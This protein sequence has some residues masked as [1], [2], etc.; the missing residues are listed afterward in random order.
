MRYSTLF[1]PLAAIAL[2]PA[3]AYAKADDNQPA[4][5]APAVVKKDA[6]IPFAN[7]G[8]V[9]DWHAEG[10]RTIYFQ[11]RHKDWYRAELAS[12]A[13]DL[14]YTE[15]IGLDTSPSDRLDK[16]SAVYVRGERHLFTSFDKV[17]GPPPD[18]AKRKK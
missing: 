12:P 18:L 3:T 17:A 2:V 4:A 14:P 10:T 5:A 11:D 8:G 9:W 7:Q 13:F 6:N 15:F 16:F 1:L